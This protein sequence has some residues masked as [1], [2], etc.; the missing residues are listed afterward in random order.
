LSATARARIALH[1][2][3]SVKARVE[4]EL[5]AGSTVPPYKVALLRQKCSTDLLP[6]VEKFKRAT[7]DPGKRYTDGLRHQLGMLKYHRVHLSAPEQVIEAIEKE[8]Q[9][10]I[11]QH[12]CVLADLARDI[13][14]SCR[15]GQMTYQDTHS[16]H[17]VHCSTFVRHAVMQAGELDERIDLEMRRVHQERLD[18]LERNLDGSQG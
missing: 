10:A 9:V 18:E 6:Y 17:S 12:Q 8:R 3:A 1:P 5:C 15:S 13:A 2:L 11:P 16:A 7:Y 4:D 14:G